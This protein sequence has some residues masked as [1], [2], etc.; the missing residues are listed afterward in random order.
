MATNSISLFNFLAS[1][2]LNQ[3]VIPIF[4]RPYSWRIEQVEDFFNDLTPL[5]NN[6]KIKHF[7]GL[8]VLVNEDSKNGSFEVI[9]GQQRLT[10]ISL[11]LAV[12]RD[13]LDDLKENNFVTLPKS[14]RTKIE[15]TIQR[16][17]NCLIIEDRSGNR[18]LKLIT[19]NERSFESRFLENVLISI[20]DLIPTDIRAINYQKQPIGDK[21]TFEV[22]YE[23]MSNKTLFDQRIAKS[24]RSFRNFSII[25]DILNNDSFLGNCK[26][27][28]EKISFLCDSLTK[29]ILDHIQIVDFIS[30]NHSEAFNTFEVLNN[31]GLAI[32]STD[33]IK[34]ICL[35]QATSISDQDHIFKSWGTI[36]D[37]E[38]NNTDDIQFLRYSNNSRRDFVTKS[39]LYDAYQQ[40]I[41]NM[42]INELKS[43]LENDLLADARIFGNLK[44]PESSFTPVI[45]NNIVKLLQTT[46]SNQ[47]FSITMAAI[48]AYNAHPNINVAEKL[49]ELLQIVHEIIFSII[50]ND[51]K[52]NLIE[53]RFPEIAKKIV[54]F[55]DAKE[56]ID[57]YNMIIGLLVSFRNDEKL[58]YADVDLAEVDF[59]SHNLNASMVLSFIEYHESN[60][61]LSIKS[62]EH[63]L[64]QNPKEKQWNIIK[65]I[66]KDIID[67]NIYSLGNMLLIEKPLNSKI[68][69]SSFND[70]VKEYAAFKVFDPVGQSSSIFYKNIVD[71]DF[72]SISDRNKQLI[73]IYSK[74]VG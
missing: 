36:F 60:G 35:K 20:N 25:R 62:L 15:R 16:I 55:K 14:N 23:F 1:S 69:A 34:N 31:R 63:I 73:E 18:D 56:L 3:L 53:Q 47:W 74:I 17:E 33:L 24:H 66:P 37:Q 65:G 48:R 59:S 43:F 45:L 13:Y 10:T 46:K 12:I 38:L 71:F 5:L 27:L 44:N 42:N 26:T 32:S 68:K 54:G 30:D 70:K 19:K 21:N 40:I 49:R 67:D 6:P 57:V 58:R 7:M 52:A 50:L 61:N 22:K 11:T 8:V 64:P 2:N 51:K 4:Q 41:S 39:E 28:D 9:D 29:A 72:K